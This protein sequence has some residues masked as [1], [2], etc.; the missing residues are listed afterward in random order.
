MA[1]QLRAGDPAD[2][3]E[4]AAIDVT[5]PG[6]YFH[7]RWRPWFARLRRDAPVHYCAD[8][9]FGPKSRTTSPDRP[10]AT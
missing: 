5:D 2:T 1:T 3:V 10:S 6:L 7:D 4:I 9:P 8:S